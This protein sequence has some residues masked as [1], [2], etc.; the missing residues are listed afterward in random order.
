M[1]TVDLER[2]AEFTSTFGSTSV[3]VSV[4]VPT[5]TLVFHHATTTQ[6]STNTN[7]QKN[8]WSKFDILPNNIFNPFIISSCSSIYELLHHS[9]SC[10]LPALL[11]RSKLVTTTRGCCVLFVHKNDK[12]LHSYSN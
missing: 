8:Q 4:N 6:F 1:I 12:N 5:Y 11:V 3:F 7:H 2:S 9:R 10:Q